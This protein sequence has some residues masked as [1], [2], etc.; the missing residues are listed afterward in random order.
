MSV[1]R[2][3]TDIFSFTKETN[4]SPGNNFGNGPQNEEWIVAGN[5][6]R[7]F[8]GYVVIE[9]KTNVRAKPELIGIASPVF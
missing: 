6:L 9:L 1:V 5:H 2:L 3:I 4:H 8:N 7:N